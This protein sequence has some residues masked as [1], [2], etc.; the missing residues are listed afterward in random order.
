ME[1]RNLN[2]IIDVLWSEM[3]KDKPQNLYKY[4]SLNEEKVDTWLRG[5]V[6]MPTPKQL[7]D[8]PECKRMY[9]DEIFR[10]CLGDYADMFPM[11]SDIGFIIYSLTNQ[12]CNP[13]LWSYYT[14]NLGL[15]FE[16]EIM[17][18]CDV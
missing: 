1:E 6:Y 14:N 9:Y 7:N 5:K 16:Y 13:L 11:I 18:K 8:V 3:K 4:S 15:C 12:P 17:D 10:K 2:N